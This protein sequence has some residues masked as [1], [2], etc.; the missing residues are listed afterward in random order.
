MKTVYPLALFIVFIGLGIGTPP[1]R[2]QAGPHSPLAFEW[3]PLTPIG[4]DAR[5]TLQSEPAVAVSDNASLI[6]WTDSRNAMPDLY[7]VYLPNPT[8]QQE[9]R[10]TNRTPH[11]SGQAARNPAVVI[12][13]NRAFFAWATAQHLFVSRLDLATTLWTSRTQVTS[14]S[15]W[16]QTADQPRMAGNGSGQLT[17]VWT[18]FR[19][20]SGNSRPG[21][22]YAARC[23]GAATPVSCFASVKV[24]DD[25]NT[26][27]AQR[28]PAISRNGSQVVVV[29]EDTRDAGLDY[30]RIYASI[31]NDGGQTWGPNVRVNKRLDGSTPGPRDSASAP[32]V[33]HAADGSVYV[34]WEHRSGSPV[35]P[36]DIYVSR[37]DG[38]TWSAPWRV[39]NAPAR[40]RSA[41]PAIAANTAGVFVAWQDYRA[42]SANAD[43]YTARWD[44]SGWLEIPAVVQPRLQTLPALAANASQIRLVWQ[45][46]RAGAADV[47][48]ALWGGASWISPTLAHGNPARLPYQMYPALASFGGQT[49]MLWTDQVLAYSDLYIARAVSATQWTTPTA[50]P[51]QATV[52]GS[53]DIGSGGLAFTSDGRLHAVWS[54]GYWTRGTR[55][56]YSVLS[57]TVWSPPIFL[58]RV[59]TDSEM[60]A[61]LATFGNHLAAAWTRYDY[62]TNTANLYATW[63]I[64]AGWVTETAVLTTPRNT[65]QIPFAVAV[66]A[67]NVYVA[68]QQP[69]SGMGDALMLARRSLSGAGGWTYSR[70]DQDQNVS[71]C[72]NTAPAL[73]VDAGGALH[74]AWSGCLRRSPA[75]TWPLDGFALYAYS[76]NQGASWSAPLKLAQTTANNGDAR[77]RPALAIGA[78]GRAMVVFPSLAVNNGGFV[79]A[80]VQSGTLAFT[81]TIAANAGWAPSGSYESLWYGGDSAGSV[82]FDPVTQ[83]F[84]VALIDRSSGRAPRI[85]TTTYGDTAFVPRLFVPITQR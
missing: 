69:R 12:E 17:L 57:G 4:V 83:R 5:P 1:D 53:L 48:S 71:W 16:E 33:A 18:D 50:M 2:A 85:L 13:N 20:L 28:R 6:A 52:G 38:S 14:F 24:N 47:Y 84:I 35:A 46:E 61:S 77:T 30:P 73:R 32:A 82:S 7:A 75:N 15:A 39:D 76:T 65:W 81:Q 54:D 58:S 27:N 3:T 41:R 37:W 31:S 64:G 22:I 34:A 19:A 80:I 9:L 40:V 44:G 21:D 78:G 51:T 67:A 29:W 42:G 74:V 60:L 70:I 45:D 8:A 66:D 11:F 43:I 25:S 62:T 56:M 79:A 10:V 59:T 55:A 36:A 26:A 68:W 72:V 49:W 63:N 23:D